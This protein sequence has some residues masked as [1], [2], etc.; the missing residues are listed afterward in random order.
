MSRKIEISSQRTYK[1]VK[2]IEI[3]YSPFDD[4]GNFKPLM[5]VFKLEKRRGL[6]NVFRG[7]YAK[8][9]HALHVHDFFLEKEFEMLK[10]ARLYAI[11]QLEQEEQDNFIKS[12]RVRK[13]IEHVRK[14]Q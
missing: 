2:R 8:D 3:G 12:F 4:S 5:P 6:W 14:C 9:P 7:E 11:Q 13:R 1:G 10:D